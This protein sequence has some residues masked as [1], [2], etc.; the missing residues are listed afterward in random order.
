MLKKW[1]NAVRKVNQLGE[2]WKATRFSHICSHHFER[3]DYT[4]PPS[5]NGT[6]RLKQSAVP[7]VVFQLGIDEISEEVRSRLELPR[8]RPLLQQED[9]MSSAAK[10]LCDHN[11]AKENNQQTQDRSA[12]EERLRQ[13]IKNLQQQQEDQ[14]QNWKTWNK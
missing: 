1:E 4:I 14:K 7:S 2:V 5:S 12:L 6:C 9:T 8:K 13:K 10:V 3:L 11:Y